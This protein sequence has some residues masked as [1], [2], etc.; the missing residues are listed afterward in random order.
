[1][2]GFSLSGADPVTLAVYLALAA[3]SVAALSTV[4]VKLVQFARL[5]PGRDAQARSL[6][7]RH[8]AGERVT[9]DPAAGAQGRVLAAI[10]EALRS[11]PQDRARAE[12]FGR[13]AAMVELG[14]LGASMRVLE[15]AVQG[16]PMLGL[17][18]TVIGMIDAFSALAQ[19]GGVADP[20]QLAGGIWTALA[21]TAIGLAIALVFYFAALWFEGRIEREQRAMEVLISAAVHADPL[22]S[23]LGTAR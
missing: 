6:L 3:L 12:E 17:L 23:V 1:M 2:A 10:F 7:S 21:T 15:A 5:R 13:Q 11:A 18:G 8:R 9:P 22:P 20:S 4:L 16:A 14:R 19:S